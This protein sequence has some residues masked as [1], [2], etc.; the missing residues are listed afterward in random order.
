MR[1]IRELA[2]TAAPGCQVLPVGSF[3]WGID[4]EGSDLDLVLAGSDSTE[5]LM[6]LASTLRRLQ[7]EER[8]PLGL[9]AWLKASDCLYHLII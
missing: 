5:L 6:S 8:A 9:K 2:K 1:S 4:V 3:A 7:V